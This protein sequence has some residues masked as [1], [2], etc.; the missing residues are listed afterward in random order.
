MIIIFFIIAGIVFILIK[1]YV[2]AKTRMYYANVQRAMR[3]FD[4]TPGDLRPSWFSNYEKQTDFI[5]ILKTLCLKKGI[6]EEFFSNI[7]SHEDGAS[8]INKFS[9]LMERYGASFNEQITGT[10]DFIK[11]AWLRD[12]S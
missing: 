5:V 12:H 8:F 3:E 9:A 6:S 2:R 1:G 7:V 11:E 10:S 4:T